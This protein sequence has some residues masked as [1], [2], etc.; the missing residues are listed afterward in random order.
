MNATTLR[1]TVTHTIPAEGHS[2][3]VRSLRWEILRTADEVITEGTFHY[4]PQTE[5]LEELMRDRWGGHAVATTSCTQALMLA[6]TAAGIGSGDE[7]V[8]PAA[9][10]TATAFAVSAAG[11]VPVIADVHEPTLTL[12]P[13]SFEK[14][15]T[16]RT[17]AVIPVHLHGHMADM[18]AITTIAKAHNLTV[19]EDCA[20]AAGASL[21]GRAA[22]TW[23]DYGCFSFWVGKTIGGLEDAGAVI[24]TTPERAELLRRLTNMGRDTT[25][26]HLHH[27]RGTRARLGE[28]N[29][30]IVAVEL[31]LLPTW[32]K[33]R[34]QI[35][36]HYNRAFAHLPLTTPVTLPEHVH[37]LYKYA[38]TCSDADILGTHLA[39]NGVQAEQ[40]YPY[41]LPDQPAFSGI[42]H[43]SH[44]TAQSQPA[45]QRLCLP[46]YPE[47]SDDEVDHVIHSV[48]TFY[49]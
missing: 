25:D 41:L 26:R 38:I 31:N 29:A 47:L 45:A 34:R 32:L 5:R 43:R 35:A 33:R 36:D 22:G 10:F 18:P 44:V 8:V 21:R 16:G 14:A 1:P 27:V 7:V 19:I 13:A 6:L 4:G 11:A 42:E 12:D 24:T 40:V 3:R 48:T 20:Q 46:A 23:G 39:N 2:R 49:N 9:T 28:F 15:I 37:A 30:G 17:R